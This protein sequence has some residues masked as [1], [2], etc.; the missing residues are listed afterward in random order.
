MTRPTDPAAPGS[1]LDRRRQTMSGIIDIGSNSLRLVI[2]DRIGR[3]PQTLFNEKT[4]C[5]L[6]RGLNVSGRLNPEGVPMALD[7][8]ERFVAL[9]RRLGVARLDVLATSAVRDAADGPDFVKTLE[10]R[11]G[12]TVQVISG[13]REGKLSAY[14]VLAGIPEADGVAGDLG[15][16]SVELVT[17]GTQLQ[18]RVDS[19][20]IG[21]LRLLGN[22]D[23]GL[24]R[25]Q[26]DRQVQTL[27]WL[28][29][30][31]GRTFYAVGGAWRALARI[32]MEHTGYPLH[33][34]HHYAPPIVEL[35][36]FL[37]LIFR[38]SRRSL[39][40]VV[41]IAKKRLEIL[42]LAAYVLYRLLRTIKPSQV[43][44]SAYGLREGLLYEHLSPE[45]RMLDP[46]LVAAGAEAQVNPRFGN[47]GPALVAWTDPLFPQDTPALRRLREAVALLSDIG[48]PEHPDYRDEQVFTRC[49][50]MPVPGLDHPGRVFIALA[51]HAR[52]GGGNEAGFIQPVKDLLE[53]AVAV[54]AR[55][56]GLALRLG[57]TL[58][59]GAP[60][61]ISDTTLERTGDT[62]TLGV[63][64]GAAVYNGEAV[65]R[66][67]EAL[68]RALGC[69][70]QLVRRDTLPPPV[71]KR[72]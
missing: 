10:K 58:T 64:S 9:A 23:D 53:P 60:G 71:R 34:I 33:V 5:A 27:D 54:Q 51:L 47:D 45:E 11:C 46:L 22:G 18:P 20:P 59:G 24:A 29:E 38:Q 56:L 28:A 67:L 2:Y 15:G 63:P 49:L 72:A 37:N 35:E 6:G 69:Q 55:I 48:W 3:S 12:I 4:M 57:Y 42:P 62:L 25:N 66:R 40:K 7:N 36:D 19:L 70:T 21:P 39:E 50:R 61:L 32:H 43:V 1:A 52:Y 8:A 16:G 30:G 31:R 65:Q 44:F 14:G 13:E 17:T 41:D 26:V 68:G